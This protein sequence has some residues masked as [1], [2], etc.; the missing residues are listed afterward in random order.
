MKTYIMSLCI[1]MMMLMPAYAQTVEDINSCAMLTWDANTEPDFYQYELIRKNITAGTNASVVVDAAETSFDC[2]TWTLV[3]G[4]VYEVS[5]V[6]VDTSFNKSDPAIV[7]F[8]MVQPDAIPP[9]S[10]V[11]FCVQGTYQGQPK[12]I[13]AVVMP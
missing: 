3:Y 11:L 9:G 4:D 2:S 6:A 5:L 13:C 1:S 12:E 8:K 7:R 10:P